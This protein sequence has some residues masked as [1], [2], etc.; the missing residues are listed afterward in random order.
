[1]INRLFRSDQIVSVILISRH[2]SASPVFDTYQLEG[3]SVA[4]RVPAPC[5]YA[6]KL[7]FVVGQSLHMAPHAD[8]SPVLWYL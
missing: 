3:F 1:M 2:P 5:Q 7:A 8:L 4:F 6:H